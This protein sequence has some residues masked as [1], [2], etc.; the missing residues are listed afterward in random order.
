M[1]LWRLALLSLTYVCLYFCFVVQSLPGGGATSPEV[2]WQASTG[3]MFR[4]A[5]YDATARTL[6]IRFASGR[7][8]LY[9]SVPPE[10]GTAFLQTAQKGAFFNRRIR[11]CFATERLDVP[12]P[13][14]A[15]EKPAGK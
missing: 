7:E 6:R 8:Y 5:A 4:A 9:R 14:P 13:A 1:K 12:A 10:C 3:S 15:A 11:R 2:T